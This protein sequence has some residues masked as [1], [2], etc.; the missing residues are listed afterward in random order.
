MEEEKIVQRGL[1]KWFD[2]NRKK[3]FFVTLMLSV[4]SCVLFLVSVIN[5]IHVGFILGAPEYREFYKND[6][7]EK[8][9]GF[10]TSTAFT[11]MICTVLFFIARRDYDCREKCGL[12]F[13]NIALVAQCFA[14]GKYIYTM[15]TLFKRL[16]YLGIF[17]IAVIIF[18]ILVLAVNIIH[19]RKYKDTFSNIGYYGILM[20]FVLLFTGV[21]VVVSFIST[22]EIKGFIDEGKEK[23]AAKEFGYMNRVLW[24]DEDDEINEDVHG[25][26]GLQ[27]VNLFNERGRTYTAQELEEA[28][29][30]MYNNSGSWYVI[31]EFNEDVKAIE[32]K[33]DFRQFSYDEDSQYQ[34]GYEIFF[35]LVYRRLRF[36]GMELISS[37]DRPNYQDKCDACVYV[38]DQ[39]VRGNS[40]EQIGESKDEYTYSYDGEIKDG[41]K[42]L[43]T[44]TTDVDLTYPIVKEW[45]RVAYVGATDNID[46]Y[47]PHFD[48]EMTFQNGN[49]YKA[50][51]IIYPEITYCFNTDVNICLEGFDYEKME[52]TVSE[53]AIVANL[54]FTV[55]DVDSTGELEKITNIS[56]EELPGMMDGD[57]VAD[58][59]INQEFDIGDN[60]VCGDLSWLYYK[61]SDGWKDYFAY[62]NPNSDKESSVKNF[63]TDIPAFAA[64]LDLYADT[65]Y[66]FDENVVLEYNGQTLEFTNDVY[67]ELAVPVAGVVGDYELRG[68]GHIEVSINFYRIRLKSEHGSV[69]TSLNFAAPGT[70]VILNPIPDEGYKFVGYE[71]D[72]DLENVDID[73]EFAIVDNQ[74]V[75]PQYPVYIRAMFVKE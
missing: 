11:M 50:K 46:L 7:G 6:L 70:K 74:F 65:G 69:E 15:L 26:I 5:D 67:E 51:I 12:W 32:E 9:A 27:Y 59:T 42:A 21:I 35:Q 47:M 71:T 2:E 4:I 49:V 29:D 39:L 22:K 24:V 28:I 13:Y 53:D 52:Y 18:F 23:Y 17:Y 43:Y 14:L 57:S 16:P 60:V 19:G 10:S 40:M 25:L 55:G 58:R 37:G 68:E 56:L 8:L 72:V 75:M 30:N 1:L 41:E 48:D 33:Y 20:F 3:V 45:S 36:D 54:W 34:K 31:K 61:N 62:C 64:E 66:I 44:L 73:G 63:T 38:Y